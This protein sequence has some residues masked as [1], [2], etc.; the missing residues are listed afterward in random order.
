MALPSFRAAQYEGGGAPPVRHYNVASGGV[1]LKGHP[2]FID[3][4]GD[5]DQCVDD[6]AAILGVALADSAD[7][8]GGQVPV[9]LL[10]PAA[11]FSCTAQD[12]YAVGQIGDL[13]DLV[14]TGDNLTAAFLVDNGGAAGSND[15]FKIVGEDATDSSRVLVTLIPSAYQ[16]PAGIGVPG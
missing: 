10:D 3:G 14:K 12:A 6:D 16:G 15:V 11:V 7:A 2:V 1:F 9:A 5:I 13:V 4:S 8:V